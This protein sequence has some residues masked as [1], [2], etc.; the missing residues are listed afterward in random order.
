VAG[1][2][3]PLGLQPPIFSKVCYFFTLC[4]H[5]C[6]TLYLPKQKALLRFIQIST[7]LWTAHFCSQSSKLEQHIALTTKKEIRFS[8]LA[9]KETRR[10]AD[11][12]QKDILA[13][14][15]IFGDFGSF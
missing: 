15:R 12:L 13:S 6:T 11:L 3:R 8:C 7:T 5:T 9:F 4:N 10:I 14:T 1:A 2:I